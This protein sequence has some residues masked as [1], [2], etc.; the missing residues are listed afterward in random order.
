MMGKI[1]VLASRATHWIALTFA[2][3]GAVHAGTSVA[4]VLNNGTAF[5][6]TSDGYALTAYHVVEGATQI[7]VR[8]ARGETKTAR[9]VRS[10]RENDLALLKVDIAGTTYV[11]LR[12]ST[13]ALRGESV[14]TLGFP[15]I[16]IQGLEPK[17]TNG[18]IS[19]LSGLGDDRRYFQITTPIQPGNSGGPLFEA[20]GTVIGVVTSTIDALAV[21]KQAGTIVQN[22]NFAVK[23]GYAGLLLSGVRSETIATPQVP[24][25][26]KLER[27]VS[28]IEN[29][30]VLVLASR[31]DSVDGASGPNDS[32]TKR[33]MALQAKVE[34]GEVESTWVPLSVFPTEAAA[35]QSVD[36]IGGRLLGA[37]AA[38]AAEKAADPWW[39]S[40]QRS[41][42]SSVFHIFVANVVGEPISGIIYEIGLAKCEQMTAGS[43]ADYLVLRVNPPLARNG[44]RVLNGLLQIPVSHP[45][46][47]RNSLVCGTVVGVF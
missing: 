31:P 47:Q 44:T 25:A 3:C 33:V 12:P 30:V 13:Q 23:I 7:A 43:P 10:D 29:A 6:V 16:S 42:D 21:A 17:L 38:Q 27:V 26:P 28:E 39:L 22:A 1:T 40:L 24:T 8:T 15:L 37:R 32:Y 9:L 14:F 5:F 34:R 35:R 46:H 41:G 18:I 2:I 4:A 36:R 45:L 20:D 11:R 19:S